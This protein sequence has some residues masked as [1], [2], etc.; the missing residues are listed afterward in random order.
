MHRVMGTYIEFNS[1]FPATTQLNGMLDT[2]QDAKARKAPALRKFHTAFGKKAD[3]NLVEQRL[4]TIQNT[5]L[6][7]HS[8]NPALLD[9]LENN[10][11]QKEGRKA[12]KL[13]AVTMPGNNPTQGGNV[14][15][16][17]GLY[18]GKGMQ[19]SRMKAHALIHEA[20]HQ[21]FLAGDDIDWKA[22]KVLKFKEPRTSGPHIH[23]KGGCKSFSLF[24]VDSRCYWVYFLFTS[25]CY[26][27][28]Q[29]DSH[30]G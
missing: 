15:V 5:P 2:I 10:N 6:R 13:G 27:W 11:A 28:V 30:E 18:Q 1:T 16:G 23:V 17:S 9:T 8:A 12:Q 4:Q 22:K 25:R 21:H 7:V 20:A 29:G 24:L 14:L 26:G 3:I 19:T